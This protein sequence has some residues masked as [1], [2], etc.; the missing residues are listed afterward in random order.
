MKRFKNKDYYLIQIN[1]E[2][3]TYRAYSSFQVGLR[4]LGLYDV[5]FLKIK[6][7]YLKYIV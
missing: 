5:L 6:N 1:K 3:P 4:V 2:N 7:K